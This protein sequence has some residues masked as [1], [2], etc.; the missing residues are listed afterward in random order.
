MKMIIGKNQGQK[1]LAV[2]TI[3]ALSIAPLLTAVS[4]QADPPRH[5]PAWGYRN[6][7]R[8][9]DDDD[10]KKKGGHDKK[11][12]DKKDRDKK[13]D[14]HGKKDHDKR[15]VT[16][17]ATVT[18]NLQGDQF[19]IRTDKGTS[20][21]VIAR[22]EPG[23]LSAGD[24]VELRGW[25]ENN[26]FIANSVKLLRD[27]SPPHNGNNGPRITA[28]GIVLS[29]LAG[30]RFQFRGDNGRVYLVVTRSEPKQLSRNDRVRIT[31]RTDSAGRTIYADSVQIVSDKPVW[32]PQSGKLSFY[33]TVTRVASPY[34][35]D[36]RADNNRN[37]AVNS[38]NRIA[39]GISFGDRVY[40]VGVSIGNDTVRA[41]EV[42]ITSNTQS[43][44]RGTAVNFS[45]RIESVNYSQGVATLRVRGDNNVS[46]MVRYRT[47]V[48]YSVGQ[49]VRV[50]GRANNGVVVATSVTR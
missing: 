11:D 20:Y 40:I 30:N 24:L 37:Y 36:V 47:S 12:H 18:S 43:G 46:Y 10:D 15:N 22:D 49:R 27:S 35:I 41:S 44:A 25:V 7:D 39:N 6:V 8:D 29:D 3:G 21:R 31:G 33:G 4:A 26:Y 17:R 28:A 34:R 50:V 2:L 9:D 45:G 32:R 13:D 5:A 19:T 1:T 14:D 23:R 38:V 16:L 42:K 48:K